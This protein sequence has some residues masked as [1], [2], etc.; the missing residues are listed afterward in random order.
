MKENIKPII[1]NIKQ[2]KGLL[3]LFL[4][5][6]IFVLIL[7]NWQSCE[8]SRELKANYSQNIEAMKKEI[9]VEKN[10]NGDL[11]SSVVA[12]QG[13]IKDVKGYSEELYN[14]IKA[15]KNRNPTMI[16]RTEIVYRDT[17]IIVNNNIIDTIGL[18][19]NEYRLS[20]KYANLDSTRTIEGNSI[21]SAK[22]LNE[23]LQIF[24][25]LT[26]ISRDELK[27]EFIVGV[28]RNK[29]TKYNEIFVTPKNPN[30]TVS[31]LEGAVL[32][33]RKIG[34]DISITGGYGA[35]YGNGQLGFGPFIGIGISKPIIR[36]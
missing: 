35:V 7:S 17:N 29:K 8:K 18:D 28:A 32:D 3:N 34:I 25:I 24:P 20:W 13:S 11:Q 15:L 36:F 9:V 27:L 14:E 21:F 22:F 19:K 10:K 1:S 31:K 2:N 23:K 33:K 16:S 26:T 30:I 4:I 5:A 12:F 6:V